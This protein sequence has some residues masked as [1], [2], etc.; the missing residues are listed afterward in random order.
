MKFKIKDIQDNVSFLWQFAIDDFKQKYAGSA[1]GA[2]WA[3]LQP[4]ITIV[5][6]WFVFQLGFKSQPV[7]DYPFVLWLM[8]GLV[9]WFFISEAVMNATSCL[10]DYSYLV[11]K[12]LF[13]IEILPIAK[14]LSVLFVQF[15]LIIF[16]IVSFAI[17]GFYPDLCYIKLIIYVIYMFILITALG[18]ITSTLF[19]FFKDTIQIVSIV[20]T[21]IF[22]L[23]PIVYSSDSMPEKVQ[24]IL[25]F[26]PVYYAIMGFRNVLVFRQWIW[27]SWQMALYYWIFAI[28]LLILG[29]KLFNKCRKHFADV[30]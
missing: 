7:A 2:L 3:F 29:I 20:T 14:V 8:A 23:T 11:K 19:V 6:Y 24:K 30:L 13:N 5:L 10:L 4:M 21:V 15:A 9:P 16:A 17:G 12:V 1:L 18:Y 27:V 25:M 26:N 28:V 22:W